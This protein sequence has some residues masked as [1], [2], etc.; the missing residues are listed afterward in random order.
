M[1][2]DFIKRYR[3]I[4]KNSRQKP[5]TI[6]SYIPTPSD[7]DYRRGYIYRYF[8]RSSNDTQSPIFEVSSKQYTKYISDPFY[9]T[10]KVRWR[11]LGDSTEV[12]ISNLSAVKLSSEKIKNLK[13]YLPNLL[14]F[15]KP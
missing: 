7:N 12:K 1:M 4:S 3:A 15:H 11:I 14:Q 6:K 9:T 10:T 2:E 13:L 5:T 8:I